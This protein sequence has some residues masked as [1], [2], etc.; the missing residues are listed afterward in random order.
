MQLP[1][2][3]ARSGV[4]SIRTAF[5]ACRAAEL[6]RLGLEQPVERLLDRLPNHLVNVRTNLLLLNLNHILK[7]RATCLVGYNTHGSPFV[8]VGLEI[9]QLL[10]T[11]SRATSAM[12]AT[13]WTLS[14]PA[15]QA[16]RKWMS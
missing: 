13:I 5:V 1:R 12:C 16:P 6:V 9:E 2:I 3:V 11:N 7:L 10:P 15:I 4:H 8:L 14:R